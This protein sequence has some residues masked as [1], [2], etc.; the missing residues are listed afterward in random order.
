VQIHEILNELTLNRG[1]FPRRALQEAVAQREGITPELL[2]ILRET[3]ENIREI[4]QQ[5]DYM[6]HIYA[7]FLLAQFREPRAYPLLVEFFLSRAK[8]YVI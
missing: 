5:E 1:L 4:A 6:A 2:R 8:R 7:M 3:Q